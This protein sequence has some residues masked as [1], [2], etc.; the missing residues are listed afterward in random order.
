MTKVVELEV[1]HDTDDIP[2]TAVQLGVT[3]AIDGSIENE[4]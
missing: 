2:E 4:K 1:A 3:K